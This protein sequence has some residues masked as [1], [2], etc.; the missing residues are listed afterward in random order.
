MAGSQTATDLTGGQIT[1]RYLK[2][3]ARCAYALSD[4]EK[5]STS[6][7][8][9]LICRISIS[10]PSRVNLISVQLLG[11]TIRPRG[12]F[13]EAFD[14]IHNHTHSTINV[15]RHHPAGLDT[16]NSRASICFN[17][18]YVPNTAFS[19]AARFDPLRPLTLQAKYII[20]MPN[21]TVTRT[22]GSTNSTEIMI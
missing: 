14:I 22:D 9:S 5:M 16:S 12:V 10:M 6:A 15:F 11:C 1:H 2:N 3:I 18:H 17:Y 20:D 8:S 13:V 19:T 7:C 21:A 4:L